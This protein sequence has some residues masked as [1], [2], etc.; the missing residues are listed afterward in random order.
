MKADKTL[1][2][3]AGRT[4]RRLKRGLKQVSVAR[5]I[6]LGVEEKE[7]ISSMGPAYL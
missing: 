6:G 2:W 3:Q 7:I 1:G 4:A 5:A